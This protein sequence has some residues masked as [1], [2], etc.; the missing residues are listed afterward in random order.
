MSESCRCGWD[1]TDPHPCHW[2]AYRCRKPAREFFYEPS[3]RYSLAGVQPKLSV[4][5]TWACEEHTERFKD[6]LA[7]RNAVEE[8]DTPIV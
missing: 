7:M 2:D 5:S 3:K 8:A 1:G 6:L 4:T